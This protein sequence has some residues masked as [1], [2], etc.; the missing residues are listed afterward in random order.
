MLFRLRS[1]AQQA[2][3]GAAQVSVKERTADAVTDG[4]GA[5]KDAARYQRAAIVESSPQQ[6]SEEPRS[7]C[8]TAEPG[9]APWPS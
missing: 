2:R 4:D 9:G 7:D 3:R 1:L 6:I 5:E 8:N